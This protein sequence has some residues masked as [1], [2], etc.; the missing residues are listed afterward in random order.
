MNYVLP[1]NVRD[2]YSGLPKHIDSESGGE[3]SVR[4]K[5]GARLVPA[6]ET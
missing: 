6:L 2:L 1:I 5:N 3:A 4:D